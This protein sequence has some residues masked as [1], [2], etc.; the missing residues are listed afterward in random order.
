MKPKDIM[1]QTTTAP[2]LRTVTPVFLVGDIAAT[3]RWYREALG[4]EADAVPR[5]PPHAFCILRRDEVEI[6]LQQLTGYQRPDLYE[7]REG[8]VWSAYLHTEDVRALYE[9]VKAR[10]DVTV[11]QPLHRQPYRQTE[12]E[13]R[14]PNGYVLVFAEPW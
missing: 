8:G 13:I 2:R 12:F 7:E 5:T 3:M 1:S 4:F 10:P 14:D 9:A 6:F 11:I